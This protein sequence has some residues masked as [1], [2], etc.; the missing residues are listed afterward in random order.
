MVEAPKM[1]GCTR[2]HTELSSTLISTTQVGCQSRK[3]GQSCG[4]WNNIHFGQG[5]GKKFLLETQSEEQEVKEP[6]L[7]WKSV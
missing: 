4:Y 2:G 1:Q 7:S 6:R 3:I 5:M